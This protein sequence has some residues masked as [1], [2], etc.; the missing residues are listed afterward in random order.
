MPRCADFILGLGIGHLSEPTLHHAR[1]CLLDLIGVAAAGGRT[2]AAGILRSH[3]FAHCGAGTVGARIPLD[4]RRVSLPGA[5]MAG[6]AQ[7]DSFDAHDGQK[8]TKGHAGVTVLPALLAFTDEADRCGAAEFLLRFV[9]GYE[10]AVR[11][12][13]ALHATVTDYHTSGAWNGLGAAA[14]GARALGLDADQVRH[15]LG[16]AE[17]YGPRSQM[18]RCIAHPTMVKDGSTYGAQV[19]VT[20]ALLAGE[21]FTGAPAV[22]VEAPDVAAIWNDLG[23]RWYMEDQYFKPYPV[24]HWAQP[25]IEAARTL[26]AEVGGRPIERVTVTSFHEAVCLD[27]RRPATTDEAQYSLPFPLAA[28][29]ARGRLDAAAVTDGLDDP[30]ILRLGDSMELVEDAAYS[31]RFPAARLAHVEL[32]L[33]D[34]TVLRSEPCEP[35]G[36]P[37]APLSDDEVAAKFHALA[38]PTLG[39]ERATAIERLVAALPEPG[40]L[41]PLL[42]H[43]LTDTGLA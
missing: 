22:T 41:D 32:A 13:I 25:A 26:L 19:G 18:M 36:D 20:A 24:C 5:A 38:D 6:A 11:A 16:T 4:G 33:A 8:L 29:L 35:R 30:D 1:R 14:I 12:G 15:A 40:S 9:L 28:F 27:T 2:P 43:I 37:E 39:A 7:I 17:Y 3:A 21:G 34:G 10:I 23:L 42:E 31:A